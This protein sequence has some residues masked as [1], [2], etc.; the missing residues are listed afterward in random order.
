[1]WSV[2]GWTAQRAAVAVQIPAV[3]GRLV[4]H[5]LRGTLDELLVQLV[6]VS[7]GQDPRLLWMNTGD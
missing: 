2:R 5:G 6:H 7:T 4:I 1:M 3:C